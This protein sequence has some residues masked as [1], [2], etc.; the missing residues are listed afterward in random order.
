MTTWTLIL[1]FHVGLGGSGNSNATTSVQGFQ[2][3]RH[4]EIAGRKASG[5]TNGS[6]KKTE[7]VC[8]DMGAQP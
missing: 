5:M 1:F 4:C 7:Y 8:V 3:E 6:V 2:T